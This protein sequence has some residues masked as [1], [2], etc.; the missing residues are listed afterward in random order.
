MCPLRTQ[1][2]DDDDLMCLEEVV[3]HE[4]PAPLP[5]WQ[6]PAPLAPSAV[7]R[8]PQAAPLLTRSL[9]DGVASFAPSFIAAT[10]A[11][12]ASAPQLPQ[13]LQPVCRQR[14]LRWAGGQ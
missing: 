8:C 10:T 1:V 9:S 11:R 6:A 14:S 3:D 13:T 12:P 2:S 7:R 4:E 5:I